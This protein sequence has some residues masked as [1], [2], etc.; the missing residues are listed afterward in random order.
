MSLWPPLI[1]LCRLMALLCVFIVAHAQSAW[2]TAKG[3]AVIVNGV[4]FIVGC[5]LAEVIFVPFHLADFELLELFDCE[6]D[7]FP[8]LVGA[9]LGGTD[10]LPFRFLG[11]CE[12]DYQF[13]LL[14]FARES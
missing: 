14:C 2:F 13:L 7:A 8:P 5:L 11:T 4:E 6:F 9:F 1:K 10:E 3:Q 12:L